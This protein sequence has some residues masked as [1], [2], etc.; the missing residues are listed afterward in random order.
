MP[1]IRGSIPL[2]LCLFVGCVFAADEPP[3]PER[4]K[5]PPAVTALKDYD[6]QMHDAEDAFRKAQVAAE[7]KLIDKLKVAMIAATKAGNLSEANA[8]DAQVKAATARIDGTKAPPV[9]TPPTNI[10]GRW[11]IRFSNGNVRT[12]VFLPNG[13]VK[14]VESKL[15]SHADRDGDAWILDFGDEKKERVTAAGG[16]LKIEHF[17]PGST[18][19]DGQPRFTA[20]GTGLPGTP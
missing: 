1:V 12:Y 20:V 5:S 18:F 16:N 3:A 7:R 15:V 14:F 4:P 2:L 11:S 19:P 17:E 6:K 8:I 10:V 13:D 9:A